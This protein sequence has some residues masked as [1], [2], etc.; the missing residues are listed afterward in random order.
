MTT[1]QG[2]LLRLEL[3]NTTVGGS[4]GQLLRLEAATAIAGGTQG[5]LLRLE[6]SSSASA[7]AQGQLIRLEVRNPAVANAG[8]DQASIEPFSTVQLV[9]T[10]TAGSLDPRV[11]TQLS[12]PAVV[13]TQSGKTASFTAP[14]VVDITDLVFGYTAG[15]S[16]QDTVKITVMEATEQAVIGGRRVALQQLAVHL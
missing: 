12:G 8:P 14:G 10:D 3:N 11:W 1:E 16:A 5:Q 7:G 13:L 9:G 15:D 4:Q 2:Q 6:A